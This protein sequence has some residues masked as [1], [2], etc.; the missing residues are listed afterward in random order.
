MRWLR[1]F[2]AFRAHIS[3]FLATIVLLFAINLIRSADDLWITRV[4]VIWAAILVIHAAIIGI[5]WAL[6]ILSQPD[7]D[8]SPATT[9]GPIRWAT[10]AWRT[11]P[12]SEPTDADF[13]HATVSAP[14]AMNAVAQDTI[15][16]P[17]APWTQEPDAPIETASTVVWPTP[18]VETAPPP[19]SAPSQPAPTSPSSPWEG[20][21]PTSPADVARKAIS[22]SERASWKEASAAAWLTPTDQVGDAPL[23]GG[24]VPLPLDDDAP[25]SKTS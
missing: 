16:V 13:R 9:T 5:L 7:T 12:A 17:P 20:W 2:G 22:S 8:S 6:A 4:I 15:I 23:D 21:E 25:G 14:D 1:G 10:S 19:A 24:I 3:L 18:P 11:S